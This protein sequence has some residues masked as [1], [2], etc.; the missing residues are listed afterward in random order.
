MQINQPNI[1]PQVYTND[2]TPILI[3]I[4]TLLCSGN[5]FSY[6]LDN[7]NGNY[8][9][10]TAEFEVNLSEMGK[11]IAEYKNDLSDSKIKID[12]MM[13]ILKENYSDVKHDIN[14]EINDLECKIMMGFNHRKIQNADLKKCLNELNNDSVTIKNMTAELK[15]RIAALRLKIHGDE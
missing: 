1:I 13:R 12:S 11:V 2:V 6:H 15:Q 14:K 8:K 10:Q 7:K 4:E 3:S 5:D 9:A